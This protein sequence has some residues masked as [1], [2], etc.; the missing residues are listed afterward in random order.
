ML[1]WGDVRSEPDRPGRLNI[2][3]GGATL[4]IEYLFGLEN[5]VGK[6]VV[7]SLYSGGVVG[8]D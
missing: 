4:D 5:M 7:V 6:P 1:D 8:S 3:D 2:L